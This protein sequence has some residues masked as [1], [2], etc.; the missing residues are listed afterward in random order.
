MLTQGGE[1]DFRSTLQAGIFAGFETIL[2]NSKGLRFKV[3]Y[4]GTNYLKEGFPFGSESFIFAF[5]DVKQP[6]SGGIL[7]W[8]TLLINQ[9]CLM[10]PSLKVILSVLVFCI[11]L[12]G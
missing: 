7:D 4:D 5:E 3:E 6:Q 1:P 12:L 8:Y 10:H 11:R 2:P 9:L